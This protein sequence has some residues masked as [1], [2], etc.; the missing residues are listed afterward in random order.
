MG[1]VAPKKKRT[2]EEAWKAL[3]T[4]S[5]DDEV[6]RALGLSDAELDAELAAGGLDPKRVRE[7][8]NALG[9]QLE[10]RIEEKAKARAKATNAQTP[11]SHEPPSEP[12]GT[13]GGADAP[14]KVVPFR[15]ARW[16]ALLAAALGGGAVVAMSGGGLP[17]RSALDR[18]NEL[19][20]SASK[21]CAAGQW[22]ACLDAL[23]QAKGLDPDGDRTDAV[24]EERRA[25]Q[26]AL[27]LGDAGR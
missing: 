5:V 8:G 2:P 7:R 26:S 24:R 10:Q 12:A 14:P 1:T 19:R 21:A 4:M 13:A 23:D 27:G 3:E 25:A 16:V 9:E 17:T 6:D 22:R 18:A 15:R 20:A 11:V